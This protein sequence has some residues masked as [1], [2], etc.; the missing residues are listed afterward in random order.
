MSEY[1]LGLFA[2]LLAKEDLFG[3]EGLTW[4]LTNNPIALVLTLGIIL[5]VVKI[6]RDEIQSR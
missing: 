2:V 1:C 4:D 6:I 5:L 3:R